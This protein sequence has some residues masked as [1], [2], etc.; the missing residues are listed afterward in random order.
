MAATFNLFQDDAR[1]C[2]SLATDLAQIAVRARRTRER[3]Q[4]M[5]YDLAADP[6]PA[7]IQIDDNGNIAGLPFG[8][9]ELS[10]FVDLLQQLE[11]FATGE[12]VTSGLY[13]VITEKLA[14]P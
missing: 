4:A 10:D 7:Y 12:E 2:G 3:F 13:G 6:R 9:E 8:P 5:E 1:M 11:N 14:R